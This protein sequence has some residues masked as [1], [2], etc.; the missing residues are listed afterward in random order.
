MIHQKT[1][2]GKGKMM[3]TKQNGSQNISYLKSEQSSA[4]R[5]VQ[6]VIVM[7][8]MIV[9]LNVMTLIRMMMTISSIR[10]AISVYMYLCV[11]SYV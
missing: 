11:A 5:L 7:L 9:R 6:I 10:C 2:G 4:L 3:L 8:K 1:T